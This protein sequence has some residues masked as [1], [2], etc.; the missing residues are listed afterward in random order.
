MITIKSISKSIKKKKMI[1]TAKVLSLAVALG[2]AVG[3][4]TALHLAPKPK[5]INQSLNKVKDHLSDAVETGKGKVDELVK[6][7]KCKYKNSK[8]DL[9]ERNDRIEAVKMDIHAC[10]NKLQDTHKRIRKDLGI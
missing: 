6:M 8:K 1:K 7:S 4:T 9:K 2:A 3:A 5:T 10:M